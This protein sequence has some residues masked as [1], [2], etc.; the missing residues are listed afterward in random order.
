MTVIKQRKGRFIISYDALELLLSGRNELLKAVFANFVPVLVVNDYA[1][2]HIEYTG[3]S[4]DFM[5]LSEGEVVIIENRFFR[6]KDMIEALDRRLDKE[7]LFQWYDVETELAQTGQLPCG[8]ERF[9]KLVNG[10][11]LKTE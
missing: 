7:L 1:R 4:S 5:L 11:N 6:I 10:C 3:Y 2:A 9:L 8:M